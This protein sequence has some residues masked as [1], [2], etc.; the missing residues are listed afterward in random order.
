M[1][2]T[3]VTTRQALHAVAELVLAG[4]Q[5]RAHGD[6]RLQVTPGG[7]TTVVGP[8][9]RMDV[10][11]VH[12]DTRMCDIDGRTPAELADAIGLTASGLDDVYPAGSGAALDDRLQVVTDAA[13]YLLAS[14]AAGDEA[15]ARF[16]PDAERVVW[17]EHFDV[18]ITLDAVNYGVSPGDANHGRPYAYVGPHSPAVG[19]FWNEPFGASTYLADAPD[20][21]AIAAFFAA[22]CAQASAIRSR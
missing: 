14:L 9:V 3:L 19:D 11:A 15:L 7:L 6:I 22:G 17:P 16:A 21:D 4:P 5:Y 12:T 10:I 18:A 8:Q 13:A 1:T 2:S 20:A